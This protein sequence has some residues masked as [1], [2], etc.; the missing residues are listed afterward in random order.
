MLCPVSKFRRGINLAVSSGNLVSLGTFSNGFNVWSS[1]LRDHSFT[2]GMR[3]K[4]LHYQGV[5][6]NPGLHG[7]ACYANVR[8]KFVIKSPINRFTWES[9][10]FHRVS[11]HSH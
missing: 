7:L 10:A 6:C 4:S 5:L 11:S 1:T 9:V 3:T 8:N 2:Y